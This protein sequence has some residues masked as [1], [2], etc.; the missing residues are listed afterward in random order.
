VVFLEGSGSER[1]LPRGYL[2]MPPVVP[3]PLPLPLLLLGV[4]VP[5]PLHVSKGNMDFPWGWYPCCSPCSGARRRG[6]VIRGVYPWVGP[7]LPPA[8]RTQEEAKGLGFK[9]ERSLLVGGI[10]IAQCPV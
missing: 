8:P 3:L 4:L 10:E 6:P 5:V 7:Y 1:R 2:F 9:K